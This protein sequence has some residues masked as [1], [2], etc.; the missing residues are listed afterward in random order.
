MQGVNILLKLFIKDM[1]NRTG[2][3]E[4]YLPVLKSNEDTL[5]NI[6]VINENFSFLLFGKTRG[7]V[8]IILNESMVYNPCVLNTAPCLPINIII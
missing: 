6:N 2:M 1:W 8:I 5:G 7:T 3:M 4:E